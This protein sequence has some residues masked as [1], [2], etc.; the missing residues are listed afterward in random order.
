MEKNIFTFYFIS[1]TFQSEGGKNL[2]S[3]KQKVKKH[4]KKQ[5]QMKNMHPPSVSASLYFLPQVV[6]I[7]LE[8]SF[9]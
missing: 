1:Y 2:S 3:L 9:P 6:P 4:P 7:N 5:K 8:T